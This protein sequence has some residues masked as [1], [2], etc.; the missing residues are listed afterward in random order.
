MKCFFEIPMCVY[1]HGGADLYEFG[2]VR[3]RMRG[4]WTEAFSVDSSG[5]PT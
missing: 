5:A 1:P 3:W 2:S 4:G